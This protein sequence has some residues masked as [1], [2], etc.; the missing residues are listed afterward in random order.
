V[1]AHEREANVQRGRA[2][3]DGLRELHERLERSYRDHAGTMTHRDHLARLCADLRAQLAA[4]QGPAQAA[5]Q[6][7]RP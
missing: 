6:E 3:D 7:Q 1:V 4:T 5:G 2:A